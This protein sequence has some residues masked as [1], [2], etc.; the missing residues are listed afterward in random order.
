MSPPGTLHAVVLRSAHAHARF[1]IVD[2][3]RARGLPGVQLVLTADDPEI[4]ALGLLPCTEA[5]PDVTVD[6]PPYPVL[7]RDGRRSPFASATSICRR[8]RSGCRR[9]SGKGR[10]LHTP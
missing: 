4:A 2:T 3:A 10:R 8:R 6:V 1:R 5:P 9:R 7:A